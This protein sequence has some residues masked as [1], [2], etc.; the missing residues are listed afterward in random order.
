MKIT[1]VR[2]LKA[3]TSKYVRDILSGKIPSGRYVKLACERFN[4]DKKNKKYRI[5]WDKAFDV[6]NFIQ[7][8][9]HTEGV[10][11][12]KPFYLEDFQLFLIVNV[13]GF[14]NR[15][16]KYRRFRKIHL[17][18]G[19]KNGK[20]ALISAIA[21]Y[22][23][24]EEH[25]AQVI[26]TAN[27][28]EQAGTM[29]K[30]TKDFAT[31]LDPE[32]EFIKPYRTSVLLDETSS[33]IKILSAAPSKIDSYNPLMGVTDEIHESP[34]DLIFNGLLSGMGAR[35]QPLLFSTTTAGFD[36]E[37]FAYKYREGLIQMLEGNVEN[38]TT[39]AL[40]YTYD[41]DD[42]WKDPANFIKA[43][44]NLNV[45]VS[46]DFLLDRLN[47]A[48]Y[49]VAKEVDFKTKN[50]NL[51]VDSAVKWIG[52]EV[53]VRNM[54]NEPPKYINEWDLI[55]GLDLSSTRDMTAIALMYVNPLT[56][57]AYFDF[58]FYL[59]A[60]SLKLNPSYLPWQ[61][62][63]YLTI[64]PGNVIDYRYIKQELIDLH[65]K[66]PIR[67]IVYDPWS[68]SHF[69]PELVEE[70]IE[71]TAFG[72]SMRNMSIPTQQFEVLLENNTIKL[73]SNPIFRWMVSNVMIRTDPTGNVRPDKKKSANKIDGVV[74]TIMTLGYWLAVKD[75]EE[76]DDMQSPYNDPDN[77]VIIL[78]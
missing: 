13:F 22:M 66:H 40:I 18:V 48:T 37:K 60:T 19:R 35:M 52:S 68:A 30:L 78:G 15:K 63:G 23:L 27:S 77:D 21:L 20:S 65:A 70:G 29:L 76:E 58:R 7:L 1:S 3:H 72:Q 74:A 38:E 8:L 73:A 75:G 5:D 10:H 42:D 41:D 17:E 53:I 43:N 34:N 61:K 45:T 36:K 47:D 51:W 14:I 55:V 59:P 56:E 24:F 71:A 6:V 62:E 50:L 44:P 2:Q 57:E 32:S 26:L 25:G 9:K 33:Y 64:T 11:Y 49:N 67:N 16:T 54:V 12:G 46:E 31:R 69:I 4:R 39:F 28:R